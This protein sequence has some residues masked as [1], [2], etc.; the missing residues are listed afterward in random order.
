MLLNICVCLLFVVFQLKFIVCCIL[1][2]CF[3]FW[4]CHGVIVFKGLERMKK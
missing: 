4:L 2:L 1:S 3:L